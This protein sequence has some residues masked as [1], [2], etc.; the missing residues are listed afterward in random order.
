[1]T[2]SQQPYYDA[3]VV[4]CTPVKQPDGELQAHCFAPVPG[5]AALVRANSAAFTARGVPLDPAPTRRAPIVERGPADFGAPLV[6]SIRVDKADK[7]TIRGSYSLAP[8][9]SR[10]DSVMRLQRAK[11]GAGLVLLGDLLLEIKR[12]T[13]AQTFEIT[14]TGQL[15]DGGALELPRDATDLR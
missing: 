1:M 4:W 3:E 13:D 2:S 15:Q 14:S 7:K 8:R 12:A 10:I 5:S 11:K 6:L 9:G